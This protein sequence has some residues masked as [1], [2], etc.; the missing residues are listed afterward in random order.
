MLIHI[1]NK[2]EFRTPTGG[3]SCLSSTGLIWEGNR[4]QCSHKNA[5]FLL[6]DSTMVIK[7]NFI[8]FDN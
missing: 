4:H 7:C 1:S 6:K 3:P 2:F 5:F 8:V